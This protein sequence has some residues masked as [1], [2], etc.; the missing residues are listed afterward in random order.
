MALFG[1]KK[2]PEEKRLTGNTAIT[3]PKRGTIKYVVIDPTGER[4]VPPVAE[5]VLDT[6]GHL[7]LTKVSA[8]FLVDGKQVEEGGEADISRG[9]TVM[10]KGY[11]H[12]VL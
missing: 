4:N 11:S 7:K 2:G 6:K 9:H 3:I 8:A 5:F 10:V 12:A 1:G